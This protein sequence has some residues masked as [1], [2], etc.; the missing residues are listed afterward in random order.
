MSFLLII[1]VAVVVLSI[2]RGYSVSWTGFG[3]FTTPTGE[4]IRGK[5]VWDWLQLL[6]IPLS[7]L[8]GGYILNRSERDIERQRAE[9]RAK[10]EREI[11]TDRQQEAALQSYLDRM[12]DLLVKDELEN[13]E[14]IRARDVA[15]IRTL[16]VLRGLDA[17]RKR[18]IVLFLFEAHLLDKGNVII[19]IHSADLNGARL[20]YASLEN[21]R[22]NFVDLSNATLKGSNLKGANLE[23][24]FL[25]NASMNAANLKGANLFGAVLNNAILS[26]ADLSGANLSGAILTAADLS[27]ADLS[28][29]D[30]TF[31]YVSNEQLATAK[32]LKRA[33]MPDG[34]IHE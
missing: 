4:F 25:L 29:A 13:P 17:N 18:F 14:N 20:E 22:L 3:N 2:L 24:S 33:T 30:L 27:D 6:V 12:A 10:L 34:T 32:S 19:K 26:N 11:A 15:R 16:T 8:I 31:A 7:L 28:D 23:G 9:D 21:V 1:I 5:T